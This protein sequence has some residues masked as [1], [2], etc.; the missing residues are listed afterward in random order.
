MALNQLLSE[1]FSFLPE[2]FSFL[3]EQSSIDFI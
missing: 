3:F 1:M 2:E